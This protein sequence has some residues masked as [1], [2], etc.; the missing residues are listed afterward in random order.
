M[1][2][3]QIIL[4]ASVVAAAPTGPIKNFVVLC[5]ENHSFDALLG[6]WAKSQAGIDGIPDGDTAC[7]TLA[8]TGQQFC[9]SNAAQY[10]QDFDPDHQVDATTLQIYGAANGT[11]PLAPIGLPNMSGFVDQ[12]VVYE[13]E[14]LSEN[15][16]PQVF[17]DSY[18]AQT[19]MSSF[20]PSA[21]PVTI[22]LAENFLVFDAWHAAVPGPTFPNRISLAAGTSN[23]LYYN[24][25]STLLAGMPQTSIFQMFDNA[26]YSYK[27][28]YNQVPTGVVFTDFRDRV[29]KDILELQ[30]S[31]HIGSLNSFF[32]DAKAGNLPAFSWI[33]PILVSVPGQPAND[34][35]P[36]HDI[37]RGEL[38]VKQVYEALRASPQWESTALLLTYDEHGG[39]W[40]HA[41]PPTN[42]PIPDTAS[43]NCPDFHFDRLGIRVPTIL[44]SPYVNA[45]VVH[46]PTAAAP[47]QFASYSASQYEHASLT[48][49]L[50]D[51]FDLGASLTNR[52]AWA[53][54]FA[55]EFLHTAR[56]NTPVTLP[57]APTITLSAE[58]AD[59]E[60]EWMEIVSFIRSI[61]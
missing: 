12:A 19:V 55:G 17:N 52:S 59:V 51:L 9:A 26:G 46:Q 24:E 49:T 14:P 20:D 29:I 22:A 50:N 47:A 61:L 5:L 38:L 33:D 3:R 32:A 58:I 36:P 41:A 23:G 40:D 2:I 13:D 21:L 48:H 7:N 27:N 37:A 60:N 28:Y 18:A 57:D 30:P 11:N 31:A 42:V 44:I 53:G 10:V 4:A 35:H 56:T 39:F 6:W 15:G 1:Q 43:A 25:V 34:N 54:S 45:G 16:E 8:K